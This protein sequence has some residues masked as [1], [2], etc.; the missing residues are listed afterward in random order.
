M[1]K[2]EKI[3]RRCRKRERERAENREEFEK[4]DGN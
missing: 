4:G 2:T 1:E 3:Y